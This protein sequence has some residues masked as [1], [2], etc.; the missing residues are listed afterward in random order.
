MPFFLVFVEFCVEIVIFFVC[1]RWWNIQQSHSNDVTY[2]LEMIPFES[3]IQMELV[4][5]GKHFWNNQERKE[6]CQKHNL[7][8]SEATKSTR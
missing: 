4:Q 2:G 3:I 5:I 7:V 6:I 1:V 8:T